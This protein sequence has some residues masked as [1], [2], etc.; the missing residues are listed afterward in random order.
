MYYAQNKE[1]LIP[2]IIG[3]KISSNDFSSSTKEK[4]NKLNKEQSLWLSPL[5]YQENGNEELFYMLLKLSLKIML[6]KDFFEDKSKDITISYRI[7]EQ[8]LTH[9]IH[10]IANY[11][12]RVGFNHLS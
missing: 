9:L 4:L 2:Y 8:L 11:S 5:F 3:Y 12:S 6:K 10:N 1:L 7:R